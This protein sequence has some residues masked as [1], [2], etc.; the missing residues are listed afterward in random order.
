MSIVRVQHK[1]SGREVLVRINDR[2][3]F[4]KD[5]IID[6]S[7]YA[8]ISLGMLQE[9]VAPVRGHRAW[10]Q[11]GGPGGGYRQPANYDDGSFALQVGAFTVRANAVRY[12]EELRK[13]S[14]L[15]TCRKRS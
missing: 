9:G 10:I 14:A 13:S 5:R 3:P 2:G 12:A 7:E 8:A 15:P 6:L 4:V 11:V 1:R